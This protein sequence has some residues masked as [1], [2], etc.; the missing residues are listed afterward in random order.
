[1]KFSMIAFTLL[2]AGANAA[3]TQNEVDTLTECTKKLT[4]EATKTPVTKDT[5][6]T[7]YQDV[8]ACYPACYCDDA[9]IKDALAKSLKA[10]EDAVKTM[11]GGDCN[12][13]CGGDGV[14]VT[15]PTNSE[16]AVKI[17]DIEA[18]LATEVAA[19]KNL[20][21]QYKGIDEMCKAKASDDDGR[22]LATDAAAAAGCGGG[23]PAPSKSSVTNPATSPSPDIWT[24]GL[25]AG[26]VFCSLL[27]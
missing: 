9:N 22:R 21:Q 10:G 1:M 16:L 7:F 3:C 12:L 26:I 13:K 4:D 20:E 18:S 6:C 27:A 23:A 24:L 5:A 14:G 15:P 17:A 25:I 8:F 19:R 2:A 11:G